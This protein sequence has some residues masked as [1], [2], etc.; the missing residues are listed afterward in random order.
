LE[1]VCLIFNKRFAG[2]EHDKHIF[3]ETHIGIIS[4]RIC[5]D[6]QLIGQEQ[7]LGNLDTEENFFIRKENP[8]HFIKSVLCVKAEISKIKNCCFHCRYLISYYCSYQ[9]MTYLERSRNFKSKN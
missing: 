4:K 9:M 7:L 3:E 8:Y 6:L 2:A 5:T 1:D